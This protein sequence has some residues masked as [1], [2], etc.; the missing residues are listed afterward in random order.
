MQHNWFIG[1][2]SGN[3]P[4]YSSFNYSFYGLIDELRI[5][6]RA[7]S[8][9]EIKSLYQQGQPTNVV[10]FL[11]GMNSDGSTWNDAATQY[12]SAICPGIDDGK[13]SLTAKAN[14]QGSYC[15]RV[16]FGANDKKGGL[17]DAWYYAETLVG[18]NKSGDF[19]TFNELGAEV[20]AAINAIK[21]QLPNPRILLVAHSRGGLAARAFLQHPAFVNNKPYVAGLIT[22]GTPHGGSKLGRIYSYIDKI[23]LNADGTRFTEG[24]YLDDWQ[25]IDFLNGSATSNGFTNPQPIDARRPTIGYLADNAALLKNLNNKIG[26][27]PRT[28]KYGAI[29]YTQ[30]PLGD[31]DTFYGLFDDV[32]DVFDQVSVNA[33]GFIKGWKGGNPRPSKAYMGDGIVTVNSQTATLDGEHTALPNAVINAHPLFVRHTEEPKR[34]ADIA[35]MTCVLGFPWLTDCSAA[36]QAPMAQP[37]TVSVQPADAVSHDYDGLVALPAK[38]LWQQWLAVLDS[39]SQANTRQALAVALG[40]KL[41]A[42]DEPTLLAGIQQSLAD[43][44][45]TALER[46][47]V[48]QLLAEIATPSALNVLVEALLDTD[49]PSSKDCPSCAKALSNAIQTVADSLPEQPRRAELSAVLETAWLQPDLSQPQL[50]TLAEAI[51]KLGTAHGVEALLAAVANN[52]AALPDTRKPALSRTEQQALAAFLALAEVIQPDS[53]TVLTTAFTGHRAHEAVFVAAG[54]GLVNLGSDSAAQ[55]VLQ[56]LDE[57]PASDVAVG[58]RWLGKLSGK[59]SK[60]SLRRINKVVGSPK[61]PV[62]K[63]QMEEMVR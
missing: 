45:A 24:T 25:A 15:Y 50:L 1:T 4:N 34:V 11:H 20:N 60:A 58:Q 46:V 17:E 56:R 3:N 55:L 53:E 31:L 57:L 10:L 23:L 52:G 41:R 6:N 19:S 32:G 40:I 54:H 9:T 18:D 36:S 35:A 21:R 48:A 61:Q 62:L 2:F 13:A 43:T 49:A 26:L 8:D 29:A 51:A 14:V 37:A 28:M 39:D 59:I 22:T 44:N 16:N 38:Q 47:R 33:E 30:V 5:Y 42:N 7:L 27:L 63:L 12:Y